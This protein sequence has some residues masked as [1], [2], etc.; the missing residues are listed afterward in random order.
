[1][2]ADRQISVHGVD[3]NRRQGRLLGVILAILIAPIVAALPIAPACAQAN[4]PPI[5][6]L[7]DYLRQGND[8]PSSTRVPPQ[9]APPQSAFPQS[10]PSQEWN[11]RNADPNS[12]RNA[13]IGA[14]VVGALVVGIWALQQHEMHQSETRA[15]K[16]FYARRERLPN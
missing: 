15:R 2:R 4:L 8:G 14:A 1:L 9:P 10:V 11:Y 6:S 16:R 12:Q 13:L 3:R 7:N 5:G